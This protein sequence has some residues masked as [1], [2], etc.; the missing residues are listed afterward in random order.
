MS[1]SAEAPRRPYDGAAA[2]TRRSAFAIRIKATP[3]EPFAVQEASTPK[4]KV[5]RMFQIQIGCTAA[6]AQTA[7]DRWT[8][9]AR[10]WVRSSSS[11][12]SA[13]MP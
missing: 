10:R 7:L 12:A 8:F 11:E 2:R 6:N 13:P 9:N 4:T 5:M 1:V 3:L